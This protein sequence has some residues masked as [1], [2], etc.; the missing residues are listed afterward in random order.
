[1]A[2]HELTPANE[3]QTVRD[4]NNNYRNG[5]AFADIMNEFSTCDQI[6]LAKKV[7]EAGYLHSTHVEHPGD[8]VHIGLVENKVYYGHEV[9]GIEVKKGL[10]C[11]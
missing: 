1:M 9:W 10:E 6:K 3:A 5:I 8:N 2:S 11:K 7:N 4:L